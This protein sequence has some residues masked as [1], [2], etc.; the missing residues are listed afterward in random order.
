MPCTSTVAT[1]SPL[2]GWQRLSISPFI[3]SDSITVRKSPTAL[4]A[5]WCS[6][7][8]PRR[9]GPV[10][11]R[12]C[13]ASRASRRPWRDARLGQYPSRRGP[14]AQNHGPQR[15]PQRQTVLAAVPSDNRNHAAPMAHPPAGAARPNA[16]R[17]RHDVNRR[18]SST[19]RVPQCSG[20]APALHP[21]G[22]HFSIRLQTRFRHTLTSAVDETD[23]A[24]QAKFPI[25]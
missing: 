23:R 18:G 4:P 20:D 5:T 16:P 14:V 10:R 7:A 17:A 24:R 19:Q 1:Y 11:H 13:G 12:P 22:N 3:S 2:A 21:S 25:A 15:Q 8:P 6:P 9:T